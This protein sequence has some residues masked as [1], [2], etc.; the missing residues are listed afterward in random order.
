MLPYVRQGE[1]DY[2]RLDFDP[3]ERELP[4]DAMEQELAVQDLLGLLA[5][6]FTDFGERPDTFLSS[7]TILCCSPPPC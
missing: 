2:A 6:R 1:I 5:S 3:D 4:P 7:N